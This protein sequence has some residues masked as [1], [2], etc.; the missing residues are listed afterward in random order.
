MQLNF[1]NLAPLLNDQFI[2][3]T[4][5]ENST[6]LSW[7]IPI[8]LNTAGRRKKMRQHP[9]PFLWFFVCRLNW[10][11]CR[12][13]MRFHTLSKGRLGLSFLFLSLRMRK[14]FIMRLFLRS[15]YF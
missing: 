6:M 4:D 7:L 15:R 9:V 10:V 12:R 8:V 14:V 13:H 5:T 11:L 3:Q 2:L 1:E